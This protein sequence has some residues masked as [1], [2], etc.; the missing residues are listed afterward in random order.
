[1]KKT[2]FDTPQMVSTAFN[3]VGF[4]V[5]NHEDLEMLF[6]AEMA[7]YALELAG[8]VPSS[9]NSSMQSPVDVVHY[10]C[11]DHKKAIQLKFTRSIFPE[12]K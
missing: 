7:S 8:L 6:C 5:T 10:D 2:P 3:I 4:P 9:T 1:M 11:Y 12:L